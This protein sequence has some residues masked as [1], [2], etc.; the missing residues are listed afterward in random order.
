[1]DGVMAE[2]AE[3]G[4]LSSKDFHDPRD[5]RGTWWDWK[6]AKH[7]LNILYDRGYL[8]VD[9]RVNFQIYYD[10]AERVL[11]ASAEPPAKTADDFPAW[12]VEHSVGYLGVATARQVSDYYRLNMAETRA[13]LEIVE[14]EGKVVPVEVE[15]WNDA[16]YVQPED[17]DLID[18]IAQG[19]HQ[20]QL[21]TFLSPF[22]N[23][24]WNRD[25]LF[26]LFNFD[27]RIELYTPKPKRKY[28]Y[29]V[30]PILHRGQFVGR[31]DPKADR[32][33]KTF[34]VHA[35]YLEPGVEMTDDLVA[36]IV[37][38]LDEFKTFHNCET[39]TIGRSEPEKLKEA[40]LARITE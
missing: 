33:S 26:D 1:M 40:L 30:L 4:A 13:G 27:Y 16:A 24:T 39:V 31:L 21:T 29:Y 28:G 10:L 7:A 15:G 3:R 37:D 8:M 14:N 6:P 9:R 5:E 12:A 19:Q 18:E 22:D 36:G 20:P 25:R 17:I 23:L 34:I 2:I 32:K 11:P 38:A 35:I